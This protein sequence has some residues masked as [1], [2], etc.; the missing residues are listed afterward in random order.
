[1]LNIALNFVKPA[2][3][4][5]DLGSG[6]GVSLATS[7]VIVGAAATVVSVAWLGLRFRLDIATTIAAVA[8]IS[9]GSATRGSTTSAGFARSGGSR[10]D[11]T[12]A[13]AESSGR[14]GISLENEVTWGSV[15]EI[16]DNNRVG[17][18]GKSF[19]IDSLE[20]KSG[21]DSLLLDSGVTLSNDDV[22]VGSTES[23]RRG[24]CL[25]GSVLEL[26]DNI[27]GTGVVHLESKFVASG[28]IV[29]LGVV[30]G[31]NFPV[32]AVHGELEGLE[33]SVELISREEEDTIIGLLVS[34][35]ALVASSPSAITVGPWA[36]VLLGRPRVSHLE[37]GLST[38]LVGTNN[39]VSMTG[40]ETSI[41][42]EATDSHDIL[43]VVPVLDHLGECRL[44][45]IARSEAV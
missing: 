15:T 17:A 41:V 24:D 3:N 7:A 2:I 37:D 44:S 43:L 32:L 39:S 11:F 19:K 27:L 29:A 16:D 30:I 23:A 28:R 38:K 18:G 36:S 14:F 25:L 45:E 4:F 12:F 8:S 9:T 35:S 6:A 34:N 5:V 22:I 40:G 33:D 10:S 42:T 31:G 13:T 1:L 21:S 26:D 20:M